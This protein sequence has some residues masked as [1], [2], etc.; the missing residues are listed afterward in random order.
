MT[1]LA[2]NMVK[3]R[4]LFI[5]LAALSA[6][7]VAA[8]QSSASPSLPQA[9]Q[10]LDDNL[11]DTSR[12]VAAKTDH[13]VAT[14]DAAEKRTGQNSLRLAVNLTQNN[15]V[16]LYQATELQDWSPYQEISFWWYGGEVGIVALDILTPD[17]SNY[18]HLT[19]TDDLGGWREVRLPLA[20]ATP[21]GKPSWKLV[22]T[23]ALKFQSLPAS[24]VV[25]LD[26]V[27]LLQ[28]Q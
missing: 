22:R 13:L 2:S 4:R 20:N 12:V 17:W 5:V 3:G 7:L 9:V 26:D 18:Y 15:S 28:A 8:C 27:K 11:A 25:R 21:M 23:V 14:N 24:G 10:F 19:F 1:T 6:L 16:Y